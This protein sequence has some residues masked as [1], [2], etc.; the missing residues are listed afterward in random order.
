MAL[1][2]AASSVLGMRSVVATA[3]LLALTACGSDAEREPTA[4]ELQQKTCS[5]VREGVDA[6]N[7]NDY[8]ETV[9]YF[10]KAIDPATAFAK[11]SSSTVADDLLNAVRYYA[12]L[13]PS[14]YPEAARTSSDFAKYKTITLGQCV[15]PGQPG[16]PGQPDDLAA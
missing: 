6:F 10:K 11:K 7:S 14:D 5:Q 12:G 8:E 4:A 1:R 3:L 16:D 15:P 9:A 2:S 13:Q